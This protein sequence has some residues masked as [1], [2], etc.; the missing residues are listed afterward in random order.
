MNAY[1][2]YETNEVAWLSVLYK[3]VENKSKLKTLKILC[4]I[5]F[6]VEHVS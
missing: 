3:H 4:C 6:Y 2:I 1:G 5:N